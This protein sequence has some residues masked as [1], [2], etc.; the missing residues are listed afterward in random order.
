MM[1]DI[2]KECFYLAR[3]TCPITYLKDNKILGMRFA[4]KTA[5]RRVHTVYCILFRLAYYECCCYYI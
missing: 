5:T 3:P 1:K 2:F 4:S